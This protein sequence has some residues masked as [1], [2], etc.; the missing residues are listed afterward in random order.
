[1][2]EIDIILKDE[3]LFTNLYCHYP[4]TS[5]KTIFHCVQPDN[6]KAIHLSK[7]LTQDLV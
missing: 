3:L 1:M 7:H 5:Q 2:V 6:T 4:V